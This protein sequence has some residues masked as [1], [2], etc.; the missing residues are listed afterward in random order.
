MEP[1]TPILRFRPIRVDVVGTGERKER[2][3]DLFGC[4]VGGGMLFAIHGTKRSLTFVPG[5]SYGDLLERTRDEARRA[6]I[7]AE[8]D[9]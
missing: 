9:A 6:E 7:D 1:N 8:V 2:H 3:P 4:D 5:A